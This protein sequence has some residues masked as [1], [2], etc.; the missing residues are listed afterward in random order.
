MLLCFER[1][2]PCSMQVNTAGRH[3]VLVGIGGNIGNVKRRFKKLFMRLA[4]D[5][6]ID[7]IATSPLLKN[8]PFG[9]ALQPS[10]LNA[11]IEVQTDMPPSRFLHYLL[12][13]EKAFWRVRTFKNAP[14]T[15]DLDIIF[16]DD[17]K[18][19]QKDLQ[20][21]HPHWKS[22]DSVLIPMAWMPRQK[23]R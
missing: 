18:I 3:K 1:F 20:I 8:P 14:R 7:I 12:H 16:F 17:I 22:R 2:F 13:L 5:P 4:K 19:N 10:F 9:Y 6:R 15:L 21:P 23:R 11:L